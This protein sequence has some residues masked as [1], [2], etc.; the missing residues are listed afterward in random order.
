MLGRQLL[1]ELLMLSSL[2]T[3]LATINAAPQVE[4]PQVAQVAQVAQLAHQVA[5]EKLSRLPK[6]TR[7]K[8]TASIEY[9]KI[10]LLACTYMFL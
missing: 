4:S 3:T 10:S 5:Q 7:K 1:P 2:A 6:I 9:V 8:R